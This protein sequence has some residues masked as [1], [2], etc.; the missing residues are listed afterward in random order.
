MDEISVFLFLDPHSA[1]IALPFW[2]IGQVERCTC[3]VWKRSELDFRPKTIWTTLCGDSFAWHAGQNCRFSS[4]SSFG[5]LWKILNLTYETSRLIPYNSPFLVFFGPKM[6]FFFNLLNCSIN[7]FNQNQLWWLFVTNGEIGW[8]F[9]DNLC[10]GSSFKL[11][12]FTENL[13]ALG[14]DEKSNFL[15]RFSPTLFW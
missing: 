7:L 2:L 4:C 5:W 12:H 13:L 11:E 14:Q 3:S 10:V 8:V 15:W 6:Y 9:K 1:F